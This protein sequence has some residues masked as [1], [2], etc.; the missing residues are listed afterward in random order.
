MPRAINLLRSSFLVV[1]VFDAWTILSGIKA[2]VSELVLS[3]L[4]D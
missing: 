2:K 3:T 1:L 4:Q